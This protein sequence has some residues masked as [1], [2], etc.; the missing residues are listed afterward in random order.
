MLPVL[1]TP[2]FLWPRLS[3]T[4]GA[5][6]AGLARSTPSCSRSSQSQKSDS[7]R[8]RSSAGTT[9]RK[10][11]TPNRFRSAAQRETSPIAQTG[12]SSPQGG[13]RPSAGRARAADIIDAIASGSRGAGRR[14]AGAGALARF[15][16]GA[17]AG[18]SGRF[19]ASA[20]EEEV[21]S[22]APAP[23]SSMTMTSG[24]LAAAASGASAA[25]GALALGETSGALAP[26]EAGA[27]SRGLPHTPQASH[28]STSLMTVQMAQLHG[29][30]RPRG[31]CYEELRRPCSKAKMES[32]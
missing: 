23:S 14:G 30:V 20:P 28:E 7:S 16:A 17:V 25:S 5:C 1:T 21:W 13:W 9:P 31:S 18:G 32:S 2:E 27:L 3:K 8:D 24:A 11:T 19:A 4:R 29:I 22:D 26:I 6:V 10:T 15:G 12:V